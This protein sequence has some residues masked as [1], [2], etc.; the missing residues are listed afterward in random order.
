MRHTSHLGHE[1]SDASRAHTT[2]IE[3]RFD[4]RV[5]IYPGMC[6]VTGAWQD[7]GLSDEMERSRVPLAGLVTDSKAPVI[8]FVLGPVGTENVVIHQDV[9]MARLR[10]S[11]GT[12]TSS[13]C[14]APKPAACVEF[15]AFMAERDD[16]AELWSAQGA[17]A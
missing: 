13:L 14:P 8:N 17:D 6:G 12:A 2:D 3:R 10:F 16:L 7:C 4:C 5:E 9:Y 1:F 11:N 15:L